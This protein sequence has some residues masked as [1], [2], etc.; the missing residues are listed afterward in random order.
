MKEQTVTIAILG[1]SITEGVG[2]SDKAH[3]FPSVLADLTGFR[4]L[5]YG[6]SGTRIARQSHPSAPI[7]FDQDFL[8]RA[9][10]MDPKADFVIVFG[11][12][13]DF[14]HGDAPL[15]AKS[16]RTS[17]TFSGAVRLLGEELIKTYGRDKLVF[18]LPLP[19][20]RQDSIHGDGCKSGVNA[21]LSAYISILKEVLG[22]LKIPYLDFSKD[23]PEPKDMSNSGYFA[24][25]LHPNNAG[26]RHLA[27]LFEAYLATRGF[28]S[29]R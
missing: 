18:L 17:W 27:E 28:V 23:F 9:P 5:N 13:N 25:G 8:G 24:D 6:I 7:D 1:D 20:Y 26:A 15:G 2:A 3:A 4:V 19:R 12:T 10:K 29:E 22:D 16:D 11:G 21:P 14:G